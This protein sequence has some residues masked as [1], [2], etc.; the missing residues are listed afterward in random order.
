MVVPAKNCVLVIQPGR[1]HQ[2]DEELRAVGIR[3]I[4]SHGNQAA[5]RKPQTRVKFVAEGSAI[6]RIATC[7]FFAMNVDIKMRWDG[8]VPTER[9]MKRVE[10]NEATQPIFLSQLP[11]ANYK[12][13]QI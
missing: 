12:A 4:I 11:P 7:K 2:G 5:M 6:N 8:R 13:F 9:K 10:L 1:G 3:S